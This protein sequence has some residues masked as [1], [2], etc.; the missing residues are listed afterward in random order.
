VVALR[1]NFLEWPV[2]ADKVHEAMVG[3]LR[4]MERR[5]QKMRRFDDAMWWIVRRQTG[6]VS[7]SKRP[8]HWSPKLPPS[9]QWADYLQRVEEPR[10][11]AGVPGPYATINYQLPAYRAQL[12][13]KLTDIPIEELV[14]LAAVRQFVPNRALMEEKKRQDEVNNW[15]NEQGLEAAYEE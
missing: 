7:P 3:V 11:E 5:A 6:K 14:T 4:A 15:M 10:F 2:P 12:S 9:T 8:A 1:A 13:D